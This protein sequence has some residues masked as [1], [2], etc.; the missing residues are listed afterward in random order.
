MPA[1]SHIARLK[2]APLTIFIFRKL[3]PRRFL[4]PPILLKDCGPAQLDLTHPLA[5]IAVNLLAGPDD[6]IGIRVEEPA[7]NGG[8]G[9]ADTA[10]DAVGEVQTAAERHADFC[11]AIAF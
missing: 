10:V 4:I 1:H 11:H 8:E 2:P 6:L 3:L 9:P 7:F 5:A